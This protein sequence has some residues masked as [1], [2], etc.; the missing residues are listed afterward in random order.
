MRLQADTDDIERCDYSEHCQHAAHLRLLFQ[1]ATFGVAGRRLLQKT[2]A[3]SNE[4]MTLPHVAEIILWVTVISVLAELELA[5]VLLISCFWNCILSCCCPRNASLS[6]SPLGTTES[7]DE[8]RVARA[9][10]LD[11]Q[12]TIRIAV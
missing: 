5:M 2:V 7:N 6:L 4:V 10:K 9:T 11:I 1:R 8:L 12:K 3:P